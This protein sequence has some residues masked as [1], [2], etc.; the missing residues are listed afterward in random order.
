MRHDRPQLPP[1]RK[2]NAQHRIVPKGIG[3]GRASGIRDAIWLQGCTI[4]CPGCAN[5]AYLTHAPR[6]VLTVQRVLDHCA[7]RVGRICGF[8]IS[9]GE[10]TEQCEAVT[11]LLRGIKRLGLTTVVYTGR[12]IEWLNQDPKC[13][14]M[15]AHTDL[16]I[17]GPFM[18]EQRDLTLQWRGSRNQRLI[19]LSDE[20]S[21]EQLDEERANGEI[22]LSNDHVT[23]IGIGTQRITTEGG[24]V[25]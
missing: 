23:L 21:A 25:R 5:V 14:L 8:T 11:A 20:F 19:R 6:V 24:Q 3:D 4:G 1:K 9:G 15:L 7:T 17:D 10:P 2:L 18:R 12:T 13:R 16:L 22:V